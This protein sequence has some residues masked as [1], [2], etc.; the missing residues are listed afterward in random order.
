MMPRIR[1]AYWHSGHAPG[2]EIDVT[3]AE[4]AALQ[5]DG[6]VAEVLGGG[7]GSPPPP[8][9]SV[10]INEPVEPSAPPETG[11]KRR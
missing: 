3:D 1:L 2:D 6:R 9:V 11:R 5:R 7:N 10:E 4:L 8:S